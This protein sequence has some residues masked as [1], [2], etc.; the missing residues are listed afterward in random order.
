MAIDVVAAVVAV[1]A[2]D[3]VV[4]VE[5]CAEQMGPNSAYIRSS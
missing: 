1:A 2:F 4:F 3:A 5:R